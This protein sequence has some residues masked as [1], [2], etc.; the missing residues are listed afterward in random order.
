MNPATIP[1]TNSKIFSSYPL[2]WLSAAFALGILFAGYASLDHRFSLLYMCSSALA[3]FVLRG[4]SYAAIVVVAAFVFAGAFC[5]QFEIADISSDRIKVLY[6]SGQIASAMPVE[7]EGT[8]F[9]RPEP[10]MDGVFIRLSASR[11]LSAANERSASGTVRLFLPVTDA[12]QFADLDALDLRSGTRVRIACEIIR[13]DKF[14]NPGVLPRKQ[15]LDQQGIDA[16]ATVKSPLLIEILGHS[17]PSVL[18]L[19]YGPRS[20]LIDEFR[21]RLS[22]PASGVMIASLL[23]DKHFLDKETAE[24]FREGGTFHVLVISG[25]H[26]TFI[27]GL[28]LWLVS[29]LTSDR[30]IQLVVVSGILWAYSIAVGGDVPVVRASVMFTAFL[31]SRVIYRSGNLIN[32]LGLSCLILLA[33]RP[34]DLF[35]PSFQLTIVSVASIIAMAFPLIEKL[36]SIGMWMPDAAKPFPPNV[37]TLLKRFCE[38]LY[39]RQSVWEIEQERHIWSGRI[40]KRPFFASKVKGA[41]RALSA[42]LFEGLL[43]SFVVQA[44]MLPLT[45]HYFHRVTPV[46][47]FLNLWVGALLAVES[48]AAIFSVLFGVFSDSLAYPFAIITNALNRILVFVP[49]LFTDPAWASFRVP[50]Y[51]GQLKPIYILYFLP[52]L[53]AAYLVFSWDPFGLRNSMPDGKRRSRYLLGS[54]IAAILPAA[55]MTFH[56]FSAP[57]PDGRLHVEFLDVG[58][59]DSALITFPDGKT[60]LIDGGGT[61]T[62]RAN[63]GDADEQIEPDVPRIGELVVSEFLWEKG[64]SKID[65]LVASH[66]DADHAQGLVDIVNNFDVGGIFIGAWP[67]GGSELDELFKAA[68]KASVPIK[69]IGRGDRFEVGGVLIETLWPIKGRELSGS[70]NNSSIVMRVLF[71]DRSFLFTGDIEQEAENALTSGTTQLAADVIKVPHHGSRTS[72]SEAFIRLSKPEWA[73][74]PVGRRSR[75]GHP[76]TEVIERWKLAG[77]HVIRTGDKGTVSFVTDGLELELATFVP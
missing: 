2:A 32:T 66:A 52:V 24:V 15:L 18:D 40:F 59:G 62:F 75:F 37:P 35:E 16:T 67:E 33:F 55:L 5:Y 49:Q 60:M 77:T 1:T 68:S 12:E 73:I 44:W 46:A 43:V 6:D 29:I 27:G 56:P 41:F 17:G 7:V 23:G 72:S 69:Q 54:M 76:H 57:G 38:M 74:V 61:V 39:W 25:L 34:G 65:F 28:L 42:Y 3:A 63:D 53:T 58:Q 71:K 4:R 13:E 70:D 30:K 22:P 48:F 45:I 21:E 51:T 47:V 9:G 64:Y 8:V 26:I 36:R 10:A 19:V 20:W 31:I 50:V 11:I 14:L